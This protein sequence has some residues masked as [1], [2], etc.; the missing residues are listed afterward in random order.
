MK[1]A[2]RA[3]KAVATTAFMKP[4]RQPTPKKKPKRISEAEWEAI[5]IRQKYAMA[6]R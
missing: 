2:A 1:P 4:R 3:K 6:E 5:L